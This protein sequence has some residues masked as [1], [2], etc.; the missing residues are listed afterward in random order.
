MIDIKKLDGLYQQHLADH[1]PDTTKMMPTGKDSLQVQAMKQALEALSNTDTHPISSA[2]QYFKETQAME[3]L[4]DA[5]DDVEEPPNST[6]PV[7]ESDE[8]WNGWLKRDVY[9]EDG[10]PLMHSE[11]K[12]VGLTDEEIFAS[13]D[14]N[15]L[16]AYALARAIEAKLKEKNT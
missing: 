16:D 14:E 13:D 6:K 1:I 9:F 3:A 5:I 7:V 2:E 4:E 8:G 15:R 12:W 11:P 10:E